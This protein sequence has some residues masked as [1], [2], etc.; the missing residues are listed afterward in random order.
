MEYCIVGYSW[1]PFFIQ[2]KELLLAESRRVKVVALDGEP[3]RE[4][5][6][7]KV[8]ELIG[9]RTT[10]GSAGVT[11]PQ[12]VCRNARVAVCI[13]GKDE[14]DAIDN[15]KDYLARICACVCEQKTYVRRQF[16]TI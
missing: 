10:I 15:L 16:D 4:K 5:L 9:P 8:T 6:Q 13:P 3:S 14:L 11:S 12:V 2:S 1:C 7:E